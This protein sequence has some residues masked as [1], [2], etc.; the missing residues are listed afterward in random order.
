[1]LSLRPDSPL[2]AVVLLEHSLEQRSDFRRAVASA[3]EGTACLG[4]SLLAQSNSQAAL[5]Q[6]FCLK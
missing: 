6:S 4:N 5:Y 3:D 1:L 2:D